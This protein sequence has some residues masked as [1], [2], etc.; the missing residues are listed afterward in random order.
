MQVV[1]GLAGLAA[2]DLPRRRHRKQ[3][4]FVLRPAPPINKAAV[5]H[6]PRVTY[7]VAFRAKRKLQRVAIAIGRN[8]YTRSLCAGSALIAQ[9]PE[10][11][12]TWPQ[13]LCF[14]GVSS[15]TVRNLATQ[16]WRTAWVSFSQ[17]DYVKVDG[18]CCVRFPE[19]NLLPWSVQRQ[20]L[21][22]QQPPRSHHVGRRLR[23]LQAA[24]GCALQG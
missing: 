14:A 7:Q 9:F 19:L 24:A 11:A 22:S 5:M 17:A 20:S 13:F 18:R 3:R 6:R 1:Q 4:P 15:T 8:L 21:G 16:T 12:L 10:A 2:A 23:S